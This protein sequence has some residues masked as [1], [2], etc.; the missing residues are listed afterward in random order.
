MIGTTYSQAAT[1]EFIRA[2]ARA[3]VRQLALQGTK[4]T[5][6][7]LPFALDQISGRQTAQHKLPSWAVI[8]DIV[9]PP[10]LSM[11]QC[12]SEQTARYKGALARRWMD[13]DEGSNA[14]FSFVDLTGGFGV[15]FSFIAAALSRS[16]VRPVTSI[17]VERQV[18]LC[19]T[20]RENFLL[21]GLQQAQVVCADCVEYL[22]QMEPVNLIYVDPARRDGHGAR[23]YAISDCTPDVVTLQ[24]LLL[25]KARRVLLK[26]SPMLDW[27]KAVS[28]LG[29]ENV[30][31]MHIVS[32]AN[33][34]KEL[35]L[36]MEPISRLSTQSD[37]VPEPGMRL[38]CVNDN[39]I[40][41]A[42]LPLSS[43]SVPS[44]TV[45][46]GYLYEPNA[47]I[48]KAGCFA[49]LATRYG[50]QPVGPN[51]HLFVADT[52]IAG[53]PGR[54]FRLEAVSTL[55]KRELRQKLGGLKQANIAVRN[56]PLQVADLRR[57]LKISEGGST[58]IFATT[59][60]DKSHVL[61]ITRKPCT[62]PVSQ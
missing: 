51:S 45:V 9:Y 35:L 55:N 10:H 21:L 48:M 40:F 12:S 37:N 26:L 41:E 47:S 43:Q 15:D 36:V 42:S 46:G 17:Y 1:K 44:A 58:Y 2:H 39:S 33:E 24:P 31:E 61:L 53:F 20:A 50:V 38:L 22:R 57:R 29:G 23:T 59:L 8:D 11:E 7:N 30:R 16:T 13:V 25:Q 5:E 49:E 27:R 56:F 28:D 62:E 18:Q 32:V 14:T 6:V 19:E 4:Q 54:V 52:M 60:A 34:C 3:D